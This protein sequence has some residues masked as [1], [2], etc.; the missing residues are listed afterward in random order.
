MPDDEKCVRQK[1]LPVAAG[2][3]SQG[4]TGKENLALLANLTTKNT[5]MDS[6]CSD[7]TMRTRNSMD[8]L[9]ISGSTSQ[10]EE[11]GPGQEEQNF[12]KG[13]SKE[14]DTE[15]SR[16]GIENKFDGQGKIEQK[17]DTK[18]SKDMSDQ[19]L[20]ILCADKDT[21]DQF[22]VD[23]YD[24]NDQRT[25]FEQKKSFFACGT[26]GD[27]LRGNG[28]ANNTYRLVCRDQDCKKSTSFTIAIGDTRQTIKL[29]H[30]TDSFG[31]GNK[32]GR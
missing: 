26:C 17:E 10:A 12:I 1:T 16:N 2:N 27:G 30:A 3:R 19:T 32:R 24:V 25:F 9:P 29:C 28:M 8:G 21:L 4:A 22:F 14:N 13:K 15:K 31:I 7:E 6:E 5:N 23:I 20:S 11:R 18:F